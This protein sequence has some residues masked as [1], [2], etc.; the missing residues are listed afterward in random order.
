[1]EGSKHQVCEKTCGLHLERSGTEDSFV[2]RCKDSR[3]K[4]GISNE[5]VVDHCCMSGKFIERDK[6]KVRSPVCV[7]CA[8]PVKFILI[9]Q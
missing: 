5:P 8:Q 3:L 1:M 6:N 9:E 2:T 7:T 4:I